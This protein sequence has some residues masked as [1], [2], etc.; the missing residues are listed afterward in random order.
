MV[1]YRAVREGVVTV[2]AMSTA[3]GNY[4]NLDAL[5]AAAPEPAPP[6][7][8]TSQAM[9][10]TAPP[11][12]IPFIPTGGPPLAVPAIYVTPDDN[13][14]ISA[15]NS[16]AAVNTIT[17]QVRLLNP[18]GTLQLQSFTLSGV[19]SARGLNTVS[20]GLLE[21][22]IVGV[23]V[24]QPTA[25]TKRGQTYVTVQVQRGVPTNPLANFTLLS[26]YVT[27]AFQPS[28]PAGP[29]RPAL[30]GPG[31]SY[32]F[33][34]PGT[35]VGG[36]MSFNQ[37]IRTR[38][39]VKEVVAVLSTSAV[40][41]N[42]TLQLNIQEAV[43]V[44]YF[45]NAPAVQP[46]STIYTY[47]FFPGCNWNVSDTAHQ[48]ISLPPE[49]LLDQQSFVQCGALNSQTGDVMSSLTFLVEEWIDV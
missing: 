22:F 3:P 35:G 5:S 17:V 12:A 29:L 48:M 23:T 44:I 32:P 24:R 16:V 10:T 31:F 7:A 38:W 33:I 1:E 19:D 47:H 39:R 20:Y 28:W 11:P 21:G 43:P 49:L 26:D 37:P 30:E 34:S 6:L 13:L 8:D 36:A 25:G 9:V 18:D 45:V 15:W 42:R 14:V 41:A 40:V 27:T 4:D 46:A 2:L